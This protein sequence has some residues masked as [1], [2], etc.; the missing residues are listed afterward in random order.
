MRE[1]LS[2]MTPKLGKDPIASRNPLGELGNLTW[3]RAA[4]FDPVGLVLEQPRAGR[5]GCSTPKC[6]SVRGKLT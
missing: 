5:Q 1:P 4:K 2:L 3:P 6:P